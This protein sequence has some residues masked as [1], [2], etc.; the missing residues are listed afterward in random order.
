M[1]LVL[2]LLLIIIKY[3]NFHI[4]LR[5]VLCF[6]RIILFVVIRVLLNPFDFTSVLWARDLHVTNIEQK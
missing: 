5:V 6:V 1:V 3:K 2:F 4:L